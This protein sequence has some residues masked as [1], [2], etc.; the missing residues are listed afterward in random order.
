MLMDKDEVE[1]L[2]TGSLTFT[3]RQALSMVMVVFDPMGLVSPALMRGKLMLR[4]LYNPE[5]KAG[6]DSDLPLKEK[7]LW[8]E[9]FGTLLDS[10]EAIFP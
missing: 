10:V 6:W 9:W 8:A 4:R 7:M 5:I 2:Q 3:R 1:K